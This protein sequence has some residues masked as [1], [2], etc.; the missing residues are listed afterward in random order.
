M[1]ILP[2]FL[3]LGLAFSLVGCSGS[4]A[5][6]VRLSKDYG[7]D[8]I[9]LA[10]QGAPDGTVCQVA[11]PDGTLKNDNLKNLMEV[12]T[13]FRNS[14]LSCRLPN[15]SVKKLRVLKPIPAGTKRSATV[16]V[17]L[18][19]GQGHSTYANAQGQLVQ[20]QWNANEF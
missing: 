20:P 6:Y 5:D 17:H 3:A 14:P 12:P 8:R 10:V 4:D 16:T 9:L 2:S 7:K 19:T 13:K 1:R 15:G 18:P 11:T